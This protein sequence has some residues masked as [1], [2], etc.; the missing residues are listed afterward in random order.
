M[1]RC[2]FTVFQA[3]CLLTLGL[4]SSCSSL[5]DCNPSDPTCDPLAVLLYRTCEVPTTVAFQSNHDGNN[6]VYIMDLNGD[7]LQQLT[8][9]A[10]SD[11]YSCDF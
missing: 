8:V 7:A 2:P 6:K 4:S 10:A 11:S 1:F 3:L 5:R 9:N